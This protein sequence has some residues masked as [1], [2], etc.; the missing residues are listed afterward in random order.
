MKRGLTCFNLRG[1]QTRQRLRS[2]PRRMFN[3]HGSGFEKLVDRRLLFAGVDFQWIGEGEGEPLPNF[4]LEDTNTTSPIYTQS[5]SPRDYLEQVSAW[6]FG[7][8]S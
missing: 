5:V 8:S 1:V 2:Y 6:Y 4:S 7:H 3:R